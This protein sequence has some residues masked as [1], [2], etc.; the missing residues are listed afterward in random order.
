MT[1]NT[2]SR[3]LQ[4]FG[5]GVGFS[6]TASIASNAEKEK[7]VLMKALKDNFAP[8]FLNRIDEVVIFNKLSEDDIMKIL[9]IEIKDLENNLKDIGNYKLK[10]NKSA[11]NI[12]VSEGFDDSCGARQLSRTLEKIV[13]DPIS[14]LILKGEIKKGA[15]IIIKG[16]DQ[17]L[18]ITYN[19]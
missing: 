19:A 4:D 17:K 11:K 15:T 10:I 6:T 7:G 16:K 18:E 12:I 3:T 1:S 8:E 5:V 2:G 9:E 13:E 14:A